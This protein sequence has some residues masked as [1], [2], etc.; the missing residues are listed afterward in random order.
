[1]KTTNTILKITVFTLF[2]AFLMSS[3]NNK[4]KKEAKKIYNEIGSTLDCLAKPSWFPHTNT[5]A[6]LE[7]D[8]SVFANNQKVSNL[9]FHRWSWQKFLWLTKPKSKTDHTPLFLNSGDFIQVDAYLT[10][11]MV[12][13]QANLMLTYNEQACSNGILQTNPNFSDN[14]IPYTIL[15]SLHTNTT[16]L[17]AANG[18][19]RGMKEGR[20]DKEL[21]YETF[22]IGSLEMK[23]SW[24]LVDALPK[25]TIKDYYTTYASVSE[26]NEPAA[27]K[28]VALLGMHVVG[29]VKNHPEFIWAT[30]EHNSLAPN[31][32]WNKGS[33][34]TDT[35]KLLFSK[36]STST[37]EGIT[38]VANDTL[39]AS[40]KIIPAHVKEKA[41][42]YDLFE[43]G[44]P[45]NVGG[46]FMH[47][48]QSGSENFNNIKNINTCVQ[49]HLKD[50]WANY[51]Y[52]G[53]IWLDTENYPTLES[54][55]EKLVTLG[56]NI[57]SAK[58]DAITR[59]SLNC[60]NVTMETFTQTFKSD[61][62]SINVN[63]LANCFSCHGASDFATNNK[64]PLYISH[65][66]NGLVHLESGQTPNE[67]E[68]LKDKEHLK[69]LLNH[70]N[71]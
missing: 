36:G 17:R 38:W 70:A 58:P 47:T 37:I 26:N 61:L 51:F 24:V 43:Y 8:T 44:V 56:G 27:I 71:K 19:I 35:E 13:N 42:A 50:V 18:F 34:S 57:A 9:D 32:N 62:K 46:D 64:S 22:P 33:A 53:S 45:R 67:I 6:P 21:N 10:E 20:I 25:A 63:N 40:G 48:S 54:Q 5:T 31:F 59:G 52:N 68:V 55:A 4:E 2:A 16:M 66:F 30:F 15:Y 65:A 49:K 14:K 29:I 60:A 28:E 12:P 3:C 11:V 41:R 39:K 7:G 1:M 69:L 23:V